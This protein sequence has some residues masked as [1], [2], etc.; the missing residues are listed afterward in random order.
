MLYTG[1]D[2]IGDSYDKYITD[3]MYLKYYIPF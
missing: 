3:D 1:G 2:K